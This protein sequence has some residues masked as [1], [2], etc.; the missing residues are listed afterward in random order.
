VGSSEVRRIAERFLERQDA[1]GWE[2]RF[3]SAEPRRTMPSEWNV[4]FD[5][6]RDDVRSEDGPVIVVVD[7]VRGQARFFI[8]L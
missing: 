7:E 1:H 6:Y 8:T 4:V 5:A 3:Q 2:W